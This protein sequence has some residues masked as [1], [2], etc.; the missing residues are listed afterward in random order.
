MVA[1][2]GRPR[3]RTG[4]GS[5]PRCALG[6]AAGRPRKRRADGNPPE[7]TGEPNHQGPGRDGTRG[8][9]VS[10]QRP[11]VRA[12]HRRC[13]RPH[14]QRLPGNPLF[15]DR[16]RDHDDPAADG[17]GH[18]DRAVRGAVPAH[19]PTRPVA[20]P[21][22]RDPRD[23]ISTRIGTAR[24]NGARD[25]HQPRARAHE[26]GQGHRRGQRVRPGRSEPVPRAAER[27]TPRVPHVGDGVGNCRPLAA[28]RVRA[29]QVPAAAAVS[30]RGARVLVCPV[31]RRF[32]PRG[33]LRPDPV[34]VPLP[35]LLEESALRSPG[36][37]NH[38]PSQNASHRHIRPRV[39]ARAAGGRARPDSSGQ[40]PRAAASPA[41]T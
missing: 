10:E 27:R 1:L 35:R 38:A 30:A 14:L 3:R 11:S 37:G 21:G 4:A 36:Q 16:Q 26:P 19:L 15:P 6:P 41:P 39:L 22:T 7:R 9:R 8:P 2:R 29:R 31:G 17:T 40:R 34:P 32:G 33:G 12:G 5:L 24:T 13:H 28:G 23:A 18:H 20:A 25:A